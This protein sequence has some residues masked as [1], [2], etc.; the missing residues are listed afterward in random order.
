MKIFIV[1]I[2]CVAGAVNF[3][4]ACLP[5]ATVRR[6]AGLITWGLAYVVIIVSII[7]NYP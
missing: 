7:R 1:A 4:A 6:R 5:D 3:M 2:L